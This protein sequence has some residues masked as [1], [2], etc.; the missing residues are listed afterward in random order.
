MSAHPTTVPTAATTVPT[1]TIKTPIESNT[2]SE[3]TSLV[4]GRIAVVMALFTVVLTALVVWSGASAFP[5][6]RSPG[7]LVQGAF[8]LNAPII[9]VVVF[10]VSTGAWVLALWTTLSLFYAQFLLTTRRRSVGVVLSSRFLS[11]LARKLLRRS[12]LSVAL[13]ASM[14]TPAFALDS[15]DLMWP[16]GTTTTDVTSTAVEQ[17]N[18]ADSSSP[19]S[20]DSKSAPSGGSNSGSSS[21]SSARNLAAPSTAGSTTAGASADSAANAGAASSFT[22]TVK[23]GDTLW[24][25]AQ[26]QCGAQTQAAISR[27]WQRIYQQNKAAIGNDPALIYAGTELVIDRGSNQ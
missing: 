7:I 19:S 15:V 13:S 18:P 24:T 6:L 5:L 17:G 12:V 14:V 11:P 22:Y 25:I 9:T 4:S 26:E 2:T 27:A 1:R 3:E 10:A 23:N 16:A 21:A 20:A 8:S